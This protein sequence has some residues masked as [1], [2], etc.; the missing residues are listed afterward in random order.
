MKQNFKKFY[1]GQIDLIMKYF[2]YLNE[3]KEFYDDLLEFIEDDSDSE[4]NSLYNQLNY[5]KKKENQQEAILFFRLLAQLSNDHHRQPNFFKK[6]EQILQFFSTY[7][8]Q[9]FSNFTQFKIFKKSKLIILFLIEHDIMI[10]D[11][12]IV[13]LMIDRSLKTN[14]KYHHFFYPEI[15]QYLESQDINKIEEEIQEKDMKEFKRLRKIGEN[16]SFL[17]NLIRN[18]LIV[19]FISLYSRNVLIL[20]STIIPSLYETNSFLINKEISIMEYACFFGSVQIIRFLLLN[21]IQF[22]PQDWLFAIHSNNAELIH[23]LEENHVMPPYGTFN[24]CFDEAIKCHNNEIAHYIKDVLMNSEY[25]NYK[26]IL[27][28]YNYDQIP[29]EFN[30]NSI[31]YN[32]CRYNYTTL[33][34]LYLKPKRESLTDISKV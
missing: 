16:E 18:D 3:K 29:D 11:K 30:D 19:D 14:T 26:Q 17:C 24:I 31:F 13:K 32:L 9:T 2:E 8:K 15:K 23:I 22:Q 5:F 10:V 4:N 25:M 7:I 34:D 33:V 21:N 12:K 27:K 1:L 28:Y 20:Q 6:I